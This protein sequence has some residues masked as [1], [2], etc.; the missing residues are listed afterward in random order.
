MTEIKSLI[1]TIPDFPKKGILFRDITPVLKEPAAFKKVID[2][3]QRNTPV[4]V[5]KVVAIESRGFIFGAALAFNLGAGFV[6]VRKSGK[7][8]GKTI[9]AK[10]DLE[11]GT[12]TLEIHEDAIEK[13]DNIVLVDDLLATGG[14]AL[15]SCKLIEKSGGIVKKILFLV[16]LDD[17]KGIEKLKGYDVFSLVHF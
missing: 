2:A 4:D 8:P 5:D 9:K 14:T 16:E 13:G 17:L 6:P 1:R 15:A 3:F 11:Y 7:L 10:Y 12:D